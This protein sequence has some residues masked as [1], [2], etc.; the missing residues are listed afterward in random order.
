M[1]RVDQDRFGWPHGNC[2]AA[3]VATVF[4]LELADVPDL[5]RPDWLS[6][7]THFAADKGMSVT[8][9][10]WHI[11]SPWP[12]IAQGPGPRGHRHAVVM[13]GNWMAHDPH[14]SRSGLLSI[15]YFVG[16]EPLPG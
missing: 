11:P 3:C 10:A 8:A 1:N 9:C 7:L 5:A 16:F 15:D 13:Q 4:G 14:P 2:M 6:V 12:A